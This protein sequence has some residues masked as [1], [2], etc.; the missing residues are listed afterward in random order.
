MAL[1]WATIQVLA[2]VPSVP[3]GETKKKPSIAFIERPFLPP[4]PTSLPLWVCKQSLTSSCTHL[5]PQSIGQGAFCSGG[6][7]QGLTLQRNRTPQWSLPPSR[8]FW[9][10]SPILCP[11]THLSHAPSFAFFFYLLECSGRS[12][13]IFTLL[14]L[15]STVLTDTASAHRTELYANKGINLINVRCVLRERK[16]SPSLV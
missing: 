8:L 10:V 16:S 9:A 12:L 15:L 5:T 14:L 3:E 4:F 2:G 13:G 11:L 6:N 1:S 7:K